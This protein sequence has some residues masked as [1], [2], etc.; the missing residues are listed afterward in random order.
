MRVPLPATILLLAVLAGFAWHNQH[1]L[2]NLRAT[3]RDLSAQAAARGIVLRPNDS[4]RVARKARRPRTDSG[5]EGTRIATEFLAYAAEMKALG[6][7]IQAADLATR[8]RMMDQL[9]RIMALNGTQ[10]EHLI[11]EILAAGDAED[12]MRRELLI[13]SVKRLSIDH[14]QD[15][16]ALLTESSEL[17]DLLNLNSPDTTASLVARA[18]G[19]WTSLQPAKAL[20]WFREHRDSLS[21]TSLSR[22]KSSLIY[23]LAARD[24]RLALTLRDEFG[25]SPS[26]AQYLLSRVDQSP[27][28]R[29]AALAVIREWSTTIA[30]KEQRTKVLNHCLTKLALGNDSASAGF[31]TTTQWVEAAKL[32]PKELEFLTRRDQ[33]DLTYYIK[34][35]ETGQWLEWFGTSY[36]PEISSNRIS[37]LMT[38]RRTKDAAEEWL[39]SAPD[40]PAKRE[41]IRAYATALARRDPQAAQDLMLQHGVK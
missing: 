18:L 6:Q 33:L 29:T 35:E 15:T 23:G 7:E 28:A 20:A 27:Q 37:Q 36:P 21:E 22:A 12:R 40:S 17:R 32:S 30:D 10:L 5:T 38:N 39:A 1:R 9:D 19:S 4:G 3:H 16:L 41:A 13:F 25:E 8:Q 14:P 26:G 31:Q 11:G 24:L 2:N 34:P